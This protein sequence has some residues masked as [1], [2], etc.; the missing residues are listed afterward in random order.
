MTMHITCHFPKICYIFMLTY[1]CISFVISFMFHL[2]FSFSKLPN[3]RVAFQIFE[4]MNE[5][6]IRL[7]FR[8]CVVD[9]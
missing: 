9:L 2:F 8:I 4:V 5:I 1:P 6:K 3:T 7:Y